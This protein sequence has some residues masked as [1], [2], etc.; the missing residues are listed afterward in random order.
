MERYGQIISNHVGVKFI[1]SLLLENNV[2]KMHILGQMYR[3]TW[4][5]QNR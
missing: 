1:K 5:L 2:Y 3:K 4:T